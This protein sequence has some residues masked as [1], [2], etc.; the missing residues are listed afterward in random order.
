M[1]STLL[2]TKLFTPPKQNN[3]VLRSRLD[4]LLDK[5]CQTGY[6]FT[7][8][9]APAGYGKTSF[10]SSWLQDGHIPSTWLSLDEEDNDPIVFM[11]YLITA[12][13]KIVPSISLDL[14]AS[15]QGV[16]LAPLIAV[17][18]IIINEIVEQDSRFVFVLDD[19]HVIHSQTIL[20]MFTHLFE[21]TPPQMH[22]IILSRTDPPLPLSRWRVRN[23]LMDI[24]ADQLRFTPKEITGFLNEIMKLRL[25]HDEITALEVRTEGWIAS[26]QLAAISMQGIKNKHEFISQFAGSHYYIMD[27]LVE[28]VIKNQPESVFSFLLQTSILDRLSAPLCEAVVNPDSNN[29]LIGQHAL[30]DLE[31]LNLFVVPLDEDRRWYRYHHLFADVLNHRLEQLF[32]AQIPDLHRRA[33]HWYEQ[34]GFFHEAIDHALA[35]G[36]RDRAAHLVDQNGCS[37]LMRGE[38]INLLKWIE[39][40]EPASQTFPWIAIQK[41]WSLSLSGEYD[42]AK[43]AIQNAER[44]ISALG[45]EIDNRTMSGAVIAARAFIANMS[46]EASLAARLARQAFDCL[47]PDNDF[48]CSLRSAAISILGDSSRMTGNLTEAKH[49]YTQS[50]SISQTVGN[51]SMGIIANS[52]L[53]DVLIEQGHLR[54]ANKIFNGILESIHRPDGK[55]SPLAEKACASLSRISYEWNLLE[56]SER[57]AH[58]CI[59]I[60]RRWRN[61]EYQAVG[62]VTLTNL[63][64]ARGNRALAWEH[65]QAA[66]SLMIGA[67][68]SS[69]LSTSIKLSLAP[70]WIAQ[71]NLD[72]AAA[73]IQEFGIKNDSIPTTNEISYQQEPI[74]IILLR[75]FLAQG[76]FSAASRLAEGLLYQLKNTDRVGRI[77]ETLILQSLS[78][79]GL[80]ALDQALDVLE[81]VFLLTEPEMYVRFFLDEGEPM[82]KLLVQAKS[83]RVGAGYANKLLSEAEKTGSGDR[84]VPQMLIEPLTSREQEVLQLIENGLSNQE[85]ASRLFISAVTVKRHI[86][87]IYTKLGVKSRT[88]AIS[89]G[90]D[91][92]LFD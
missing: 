71:G 77:L 65:L 7:L 35:A 85:I 52:N 45:S 87:N 17:L 22:T 15:T 21:H 28:E 51:H 63:E 16:K 9:S 26:L 30:E 50:L 82:L 29:P 36:D 4:E 83:H 37:L 86:S 89:M 61:I 92:K 38:V 59:D 23:R 27:Y 60:A 5:A 19:F 41:A 44:L 88:Q 3:F 53:A 55:A 73:L 69:W 91:L 25:S 47:P 33:S 79:F 32:P 49:A 72:K 64:H 14:L 67:S 13:Q 2:S 46:G 8:I 42:R 90:R 66:E 20:D 39:S 56:E 74:V 34:N 75:L 68:L 54:E 81:R 70:L 11:Q 48:S 76:N 78:L 57:Y 12:L 62:F 40:V 6:G 43:I 58:L 31:R 18:N 84:S 1:N 24:R 80:K 10:V